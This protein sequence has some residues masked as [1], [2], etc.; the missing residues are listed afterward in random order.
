ML[1]GVFS[2]PF[3]SSKR[4]VVGELVMVI[5]LKFGRTTR[6]PHT[7]TSK[8]LTLIEVYLSLKWPKISSYKMYLV[9]INILLI[10]FFS[11]LILTT[12]NKFL[13]LT[14]T[15]R[16]SICGYCKI[17]KCYVKLARVW[18]KKYEN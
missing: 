3:G 2:T 15:T 18:G 8:S 4:V 9:G 11:P 1:G 6:F 5:I 10:L 12:F 16:M 13:S 7:P 17:E 14:P